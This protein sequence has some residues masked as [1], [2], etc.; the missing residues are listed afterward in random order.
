MF[1]TQTRQRNVWSFIVDAISEAVGEPFVIRQRMKVSGGSICSTFK[2]DDGTTAYLVK[3]H[4]A[5]ALWAFEA[6]RAGLDL[7]RA[8]SGALRVPEVVCTGSAQD[9]SWLVL[10]FITLRPVTDE[11]A[12]RL[13]VALAEV[14]RKLG[15][16]YGWDRDN[17]IGSSRQVNTPDDRWASFFREQ[18]LARQLKMA[19]EN[20]L[21]IA[22]LRKGELVLE[23]CDRMLEGHQPKPSLLHGDLWSGNLAVDGEGRAVL[24]DPAV[25]YGD[26]E[27]DLAMTRLFGGVPD[28]FLRA[29]HDTWPIDHGFEQRL[30]LYN[31]YHLLN[32]ANMFGG[33]YVRQAEK[34][35]DRILMSV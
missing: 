9:R 31:L 11:S 1:I 17:A 19:E 6:E 21:D 28:S 7:L 30:H 23:A 10:E 32:H 12:A 5:E 26:R 27:C 18:R 8:A 22:L 33:G 29:Y 16:H 35:M 14:H 15:P 3:L 20:R 34:A 13:G 2:V 25:Y 4:R 24:F